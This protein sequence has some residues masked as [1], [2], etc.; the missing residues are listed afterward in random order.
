MEKTNR[1]VERIVLVT[2]S[3]DYDHGVM[4]LKWLT[5]A[6][7]EYRCTMAVL[8]GEREMDDLVVVAALR[9]R[10]NVRIVTAD[11]LSHQEMIDRYKPVLGLAFPLP[12][13]SETHD[14]V[15]R[16]RAAGI[17]VVEVS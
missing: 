8:S 4:V 2:G 12:E 10:M 17:P 13:D 6:R 3:R 9:L 1:P 11:E 5:T 16:M 15:K 14:C 7:E